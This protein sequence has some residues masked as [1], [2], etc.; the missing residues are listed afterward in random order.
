MGRL[1][2]HSRLSNQVRRVRAL[3]LTATGAAVLAA[4]FMFVPNA[5]AATG[6]VALKPLPTGV[7]RPVPTALSATLEGIRSTEAAA[8]YGTSTAPA[9]A[10]RKTSII[11][12]GDSEISGEGVDNFIPATNTSTNYCHRSYD[13]AIL[14]TGLI[15]DVPINVACSGAQTRHLI[16]AAQGGG[17]YQYNDLNQ[18]D[19][20]SIKARN[21]RVGMVLLVI[22]A[23]DPG[24]IEFP[25]VMTDCVQRRILFQGNCWPDYT[26]SWQAR[27]NVTQA[28]VTRAITSVRTTM[29]N[30]GYL[31][32]DYELVVMSYPSPLSPDVEDNPNFPGWYDG[33]CLGYLKDL[34][35][36][37]NKAVPMFA[38]AV[39]NAAL[40]ASGVRYLDNSRLFDGHEVCAPDPWAR[41]M[42][43][44]DGNILNLDS[45]NTQMSFHPNVLGAAAIASCVTQIYASTAAAASCVDNNHSGATTLYPGPLS[46]QRLRNLGNGLC[47]EAEGY[48]SRVGTKLLSYPCTGGRSQGF[49]YNP[50]TSTLHSQLSQDRCID[51]PNGSFTAGA[52]LRLWNCNGATAQKW[53]ISG[54]LIK[55]VGNANLC[56]TFGTGS[57]YLGEQATL[58]TCSTSS[59]WDQFSRQTQV[60]TWTELKNKASGLCLDPSGS[61]S[62][63]ANNVALLAYACDGGTD[64]KYWYN[65]VS[66][67]LHIYANP[68]YC[69]DTGGS[70]SVG[71]AVKA[72]KCNESTAAKQAWVWASD[73]TVRLKSNQSL[74]AAPASTSTSTVN[75]RTLVS[76][77]TSQQWAAGANLAAQWGFNYSDFIG[78]LTY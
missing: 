48:N 62:A 55:S 37:R 16:P 47:V 52:A 3:A 14:K 22:G 73:G 46:F 63:L 8:L 57:V 66:G 19:S 34:A 41:G 9:L 42:Y 5:A 18:G 50:T 68:L 70:T 12:L 54:N 71:G 17:E 2:D 76:G 35:F 45:H 38:Q 20:L 75:L 58:Q 32:G 72:Y 39:Q 1:L 36:G 15:V 61:A 25:V 77:S 26:D 67:R 7:T 65:D 29:T 24:S 78:T 44:A 69:V 28:N 21:T 4:S 49:W 40:A 64:Q 11:S 56:I 10:S 59:T 60:T 31:N 33:G 23:N 53:A 51:V 43:F 13:S 30:A 27:A 74:V 6:T